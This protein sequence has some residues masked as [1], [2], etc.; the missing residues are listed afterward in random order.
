MWDRW[1]SLSKDCF[2]LFPAHPLQEPCL[3]GAGRY[4]LSEQET[5]SQAADML[6]PQKAGTALSPF[7][8]P[9]VQGALFSE[10]APHTWSA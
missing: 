6:Y 9:W 3:G 1:G 2:E 7:S 10:C 4:P 5:L 8:I